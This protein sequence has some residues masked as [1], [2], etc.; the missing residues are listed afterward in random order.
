MAGIE[1]FKGSTTAT[2]GSVGP[3]IV[4]GVV[5]EGSVSSPVPSPVAEFRELSSVSAILTLEQ[6]WKKKIMMNP[7]SKSITSCLN[8][9]DDFFISSPCEQ[10]NTDL[11]GYRDAE[12]LNENANL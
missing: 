5:T 9:K 10:S 2:N 11:F 3:G 6:F 8:L 1:G 12:L 7:E 4:V